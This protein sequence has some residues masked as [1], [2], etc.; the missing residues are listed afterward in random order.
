MPENSDLR[1]FS[2]DVDESRVVS[3]T[4][5]ELRKLHMDSWNAAI[6]YAV[7]NHGQFDFADERITVR[8]RTCHRITGVN[9][10]RCSV[11]GHELYLNQP[12][13]DDGRYC[14][15]CGARVMEE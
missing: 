7:G 15:G 2:P 9:H 8:E 5:G 13:G 4:V 1:V 6:D 3:V 12:W 14:P 11:C 10:G